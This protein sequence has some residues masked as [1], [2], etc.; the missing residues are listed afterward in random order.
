MFPV[1]LIAAAGT[2]LS[3]LAAHAALVVVGAR[4]WR[5]NSPGARRGLAGGLFGLAW[6]AALLGLVGAF[7]FGLLP[8]R[9]PDWLDAAAARGLFALW[10][11]AQAF[12][13]AAA[14]AA[15]GSAA[16]SAAGAED[17]RGAA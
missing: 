8:A 9:P 17:V 1:L 14:W 15:L 4:A 16:G 10:G 11:L 12:Q 2:G 5:W 6:P 3:Y 13:I 7:W